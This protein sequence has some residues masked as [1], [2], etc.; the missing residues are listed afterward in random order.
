MLKL[1]RISFDHHHSFNLDHHH[2]FDLDYSL[3]MEMM[4][5]YVPTVSDTTIKMFRLTITVRLT[6]TISY[7]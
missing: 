7:I 2:S 5:E 6:M 3:K 1:T 4:K